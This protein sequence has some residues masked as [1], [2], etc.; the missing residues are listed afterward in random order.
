VQYGSLGPGEKSRRC[1]CCWSDFLGFRPLLREA[2]YSDL[3][4]FDIALDRL[5]LLEKSLRDA[6]LFPAEYIINLETILVVNDGVARNLDY[7][8]GQG[9]HLV[10]TGS[11]AS[12]E[13][14][15]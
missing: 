7:W 2:R 13:H 15:T 4:E 6:I 3:N 11:H 9:V 1:L 12:F 8:D 10:C 14:T 5:H